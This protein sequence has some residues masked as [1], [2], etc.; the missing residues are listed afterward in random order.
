[1]LFLL[2]PV[3]WTFSAVCHLTDAFEQAY[4]PT[5]SPSPAPF[6]C[7]FS[8]FI[9]YYYQAHQCGAFVWKNR[10]PSFAIYT[11]SHS[12]TFLCADCVTYNGSFVIIHKTLRQSKQN[13]HMHI[14]CHTERERL[15]LYSL[16]FEQNQCT[17]ELI[18]TQNT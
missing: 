4:L 15:W 6:L 9:F 8:V 7:F 5:P 14:H 16:P 2:W 18:S 10:H 13:R 12:L 3:A 17:R 11:L 1:M